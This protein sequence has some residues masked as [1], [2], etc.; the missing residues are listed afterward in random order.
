MVE[1]VVPF[2]EDH[3]AVLEVTLHDADEALGPRVLEPVHAEALHLGH[4]LV[5]NV[6][7]FEVDIVSIF[8]LNITISHN[9]PQQGLVFALSLLYLLLL[10]LYLPYRNTWAG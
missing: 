3:L 7:L 4:E 9:I 6:E 2:A 10:G 8:D 5:V 1:E